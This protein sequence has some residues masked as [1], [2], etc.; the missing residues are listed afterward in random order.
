[1]MMSLGLVPPAIVMSQPFESLRFV[2]V[3]AQAFPTLLLL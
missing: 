3:S 2:V 1:M